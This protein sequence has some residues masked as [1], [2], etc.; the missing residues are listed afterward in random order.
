MKRLLLKI[1]QLVIGNY[2]PIV[3]A[4]YKRIKTLVPQRN[5]CPTGHKVN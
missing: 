1:L 5:V 2:I 3:D 4:L